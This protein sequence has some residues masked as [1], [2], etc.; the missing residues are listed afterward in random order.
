MQLSRLY[1]MYSLPSSSPAVR[2]TKFREGV[3]KIEGDNV[4]T[5][6]QL[7]RMLNEFE[8]LD[9]RLTPHA[10]ARVLLSDN[11]EELEAG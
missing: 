6:H 11:R 1:D 5:G 2:Q 10:V 8:L 3:P 7:L 9:N 4:L